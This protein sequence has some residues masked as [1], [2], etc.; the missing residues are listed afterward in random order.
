MDQLRRELWGGGGGSSC[1]V[2]CQFGN[3]PFF[4]LGEPCWSSGFVCV[5]R[6]E[7]RNLLFILVEKCSRTS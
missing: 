2:I 4:F 1:R 7:G 3:G 6:C 5:G